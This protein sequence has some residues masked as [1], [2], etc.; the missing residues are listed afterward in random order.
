M[1]LLPKLLIFDL[2]KEVLGLYG[3]EE[4]KVRKMEGGKVEISTNKEEPSALGWKILVQAGTGESTCVLTSFQSNPLSGLQVLQLC[5]ETVH[6]IY[7]K[8]L[9]LGFSRKRET[10]DFSWNIH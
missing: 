9:C 3:A 4:G 1:F 6:R 7:M 2:Q 5:L 10:N 8:L